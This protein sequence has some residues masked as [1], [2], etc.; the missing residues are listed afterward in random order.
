M[1]EQM[2]KLFESRMKYAI[3][4]LNI[5]WVSHHANRSDTAI[6]GLEKCLIDL[7]AL[8]AVPNHIPDVGNM[9]QPAN[10][11]EDA[12]NMVQSQAQQPA[13]EALQAENAKLKEESQNYES[14]LR[15][16]QEWSGEITLANGEL[17]KAN[18]EQV[19]EIEALRKQ[20]EEI[21]E[22]ASF[23]CS[24]LAHASNNDDLYNA[25]Y[26]GLRGALYPE[27]KLISESAQKGTE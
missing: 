9:V 3:E 10:H 24:A 7:A 1:K 12:L 11:S 13:L 2:I 6:D 18:K 16:V 22:K 8:S 14:A 5:L 17:R 21:K 26:L 4:C 25:A 19:K 20:V 23:A 27:L 15:I